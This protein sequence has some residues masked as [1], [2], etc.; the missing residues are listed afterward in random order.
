MRSAWFPFHTHNKQ[1]AVRCLTAC[2]KR[3]I[4]WCCVPHGNSPRH[5]LHDVGS[6]NA[7]R[8]RSFFGGVG[9]LIQDISIRASRKKPQVVLLSTA[10]SSK[11]FTDDMVQ[12]GGQQAGERPPTDV[13]GG[14]P[15]SITKLSLMQSPQLRIWDFPEECSHGL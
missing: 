6:R 7:T 2:S 8:R 11:A 15:W 1:A 10:V 3:A 12:T 9:G 5:P 13:S 14:A 4:L